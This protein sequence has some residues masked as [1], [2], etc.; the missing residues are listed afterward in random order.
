MTAPHSHDGTSHDGI[1]VLVRT[2][3]ILLALD[4]APRLEGLA[5]RIQHLWQHLL[6]T[7][8]TTAPDLHLSFAPPQFAQENAIAVDD[9]PEATY[10]VS[11]YVTRAI[12]GH[13]AGQQL[14]LHA[15]AVQLGRLGV[16]LVVGASGAGKS[17][18][19]VRLA[20]GPEGRYLTDE[21]TILDPVDLTVTAYPKPISLRPDSTGGKR[22]LCLEDLELTALPT[23]EAPSHLLLL[24]R[25]ETCPAG[26]Q[27]GCALRR[28]SLSEALLRLVPQTSSL[29][30]IP[31]GLVALA[32]LI[33]RTGG[34]LEVRYREAAQLR[35]LL[36]HAPEPQVESFAEI[37]LPPRPSGP[38]RP[39]CYR[40]RPVSQALALTDGVFVLCEREGLFLPGLTGMIWEILTTD[41]E[42]D[43]AQLDAEITRH[44]GPTENSREILRGVLTELVT[45]G[46]VIEG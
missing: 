4:F 13:Q 42:Q 45:A 2:S 38:V 16:V 22:D 36:E 32:E 35:D 33:S 24:Q 3:G 18:A 14:M 31:G 29:R 1:R 17:T 6:V 7:D 46:Y 10:T 19:T 41:G 26:E 5:E 12:I 40:A 21:L 43:L 23:A 9:S 15:G 44:L 20:T 8:A 30:E 27:E 39:G 34:A 37:P 25:D 11:G 28:L